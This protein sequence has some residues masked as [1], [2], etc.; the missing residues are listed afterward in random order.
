MLFVLVFNSVLF[1][2]TFIQKTLKNLFFSDIENSHDIQSGH[3]HGRLAEAISF[4]L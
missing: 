4:M 3:K 2:N 1:W